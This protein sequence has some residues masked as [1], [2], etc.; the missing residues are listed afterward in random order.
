M[1]NQKNVA[2]LVA[3]LFLLGGFTLASAAVET[4]DPTPTSVTNTA[5]APAGPEVEAPEAA[6]TAEAPEVAEVPDIAE[7][8]E[9][10]EGPDT[11]DTSPDVSP[12]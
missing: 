10:N 12:K 4:P 9:V 2:K 11:P 6:E 1:L 8:P 3:T 7:V 5:G